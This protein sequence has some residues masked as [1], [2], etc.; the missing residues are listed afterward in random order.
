MAAVPLPGHAGP[1]PRSGDDGR[2]AATGPDCASESWADDDRDY[3]EDDPER[4]LP[5]ELAG[6]SA[7]EL[8]ELDPAA[9]DDP[10]SG[11]GDGR[12]RP[13]APWPLCYGDS[14]D[15]SALLPHDG[16]GG[17]PGFADGG[18]LDTLPAGLG[19]AGHADQAYEELDTLNDDSLIGVLRAWRRLTSWAQARELAVLTALA[20][21]RPADGYP[22]AEPGEVPSKVSPYLDAEVAA[23]LTL[24]PAS[25]QGTMGL[26]LGF[27]RRPATW[28]ALEQ[29][30]LDLPRA[31]LIVELTATL[32][33]DH[34]AA[35]EAAVLPHAPDMTTGQLRRALRKAILTVDP[36]AIK[37]QRERAEQHAR[38]EAWADPEGTS[39]LTGRNL[40]PAQVLA[41]D[42]R[43][44][45]IATAWK[46]RGAQGGMD[47][48][49]AWAYLAL[50]NGIN[51]DDPPASLLP[52]QLRP[53]ASAGE[54]LPGAQQVPPGLHHP[55]PADELPPLAGQIHLT[56]PLTTLL[57]H[58][59]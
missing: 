58:G 55:P 32:D 54:P 9:Y 51:T 25:G 34:A 6:L 14:G 42:K 3:D 26:A 39:T 10:G 20:R 23:A 45:R 8:Y 49:R 44:T 28:A 27:A 47:R 19:L 18:P 43:L 15:L 52:D 59:E 38:V 40:P 17:G 57:G 5:P 36:T 46:R 30:W 48:L 1:T 37:R 35:V 31:R 33:D 24:T 41:A 56:V 21:R 53:A 12:R 4:G 2:P 29:G 7:Q 16:T 13:P 22:P 11:L 50:L